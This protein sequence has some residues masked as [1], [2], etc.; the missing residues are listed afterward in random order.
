ML[1]AA[2]DGIPCLVAAGGGGIRRYLERYL[3][4]TATQLAIALVPLSTGF[5][6]TGGGQRP[7]LRAVKKSNLVH[8]PSLR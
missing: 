2:C 7:Y 3:T 4:I 6:I 5:T 8:M 1:P